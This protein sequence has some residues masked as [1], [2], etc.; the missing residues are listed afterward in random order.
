M[1][2]SKLPFL[3]QLLNSLAFLPLLFL[4][5]PCSIIIPHDAVVTRTVCALEEEEE[6]EETMTNR[7]DTK[8]FF[9]RLTA[10]HDKRKTGQRVFRAGIMDGL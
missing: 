8:R 1:L 9:S 4:A 10:G 2:Y 5:I 7:V 6:E 3:L